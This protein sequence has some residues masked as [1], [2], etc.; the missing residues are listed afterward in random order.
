MWKGHEKIKWWKFL[1]WRLLPTTSP[2][3]KVPIL[4]FCSQ[5]ENIITAQHTVGT[6]DY[7]IQTDNSFTNEV[8]RSFIRTD[9][10][11]KDLY[12]PTQSPND[13]NL[14]VECLKDHSQCQLLIN[15]LSNR[16]KSQMC[17]K[18]LCRCVHTT[19]TLQLYVWPN[20]HGQLVCM[21]LLQAWPERRKSLSQTL[22]K[23]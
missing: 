19:Q 18:M 6:W 4:N 5:L 12:Q 9:V 23:L 14:H 15:K 20:T 21:F 11:Y 13:I 3:E 10:V 16:N 17:S 7:S 8:T 1:N 2:S 22:K